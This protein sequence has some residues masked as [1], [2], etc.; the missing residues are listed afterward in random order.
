M[1]LHSN[2]EIDYSNPPRASDNRTKILIS[3]TSNVRRARQHLRIWLGHFETMVSEVYLGKRK[4]LCATIIR[5]YLLI[6][7]K[8]FHLVIKARWVLYRISIF[9]DP[10]RSR[11]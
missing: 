3:K 9:R 5:C 4:G 10:I 6:L 11:G 2:R 7:S 1:P 8:F